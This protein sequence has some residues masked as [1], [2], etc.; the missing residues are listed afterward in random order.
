M[1]LIKTKIQNIFVLFGSFVC[2]LFSPLSCIAL[3]RSLVATLGKSYMRFE[4]TSRVN[5]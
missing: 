3:A 4:D 1:P 5:D 2:L